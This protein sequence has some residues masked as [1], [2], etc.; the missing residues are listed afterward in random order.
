[1]P[2]VYISPSHQGN[3]PYA[4]GHGSE[5]YWMEQVGVR[6]ERLLHLSDVETKM[7]D[8]HLSLAGVCNGSNNFTPDCHI[9]IHSNAGGGE[10]TEI[11]YFPFSEKGK[12]L[13]ECVYKYVAPLSPGRDRGIKAND[14][15]Y[16]LKNTDAPAVI[17]EIEFHDKETL[18]RWIT[19]HVDEIAKA[20]AQ[21]IA[22]YLGVRLRQE[23]TDIPSPW[24]AG[25]WKKAVTKG[26]LDGTR[27][28]DSATRE[29]LAVVLD[30]LGL[31]EGS[32]TG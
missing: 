27:P 32:R 4:G 20:I 28:H 13:A 22:D 7:S 14:T 9:A 3:N 21:G 18:A 30:R 19:E 25:S 6:V 10:G 23:E 15:Y 1:M 16:E 24:A 11:W 8:P 26:T 5:A 2:K 29:E 12:R 31:L 17:V